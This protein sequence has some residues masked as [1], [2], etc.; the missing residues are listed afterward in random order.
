MMTV[1]PVYQEYASWL[2]HD[3]IQSR[4]TGSLSEELKG[5]RYSCT[6]RAQNAMQN[7]HNALASFEPGRFYALKSAAIGAGF[8]GV[9]LLGALETIVRAGL[10]AIGLVF[11]LL[12]K[13]CF[14]H[15]TSASLYNRSINC[16][17]MTFYNTLQAAISVGTQW[18]HS[19]D[20]I[21]YRGQAN[22]YIHFDK[23]QELD[24]LEQ[25]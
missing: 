21:N 15:K 11:S 3:G 19:R 16:F 1:N 4:Q 7:H 13:F 14:M 25:V 9:S 22:C 2:H 23:P 5:C 20:E 18:T 24:D 17:S 8:V 6:A 12:A 10:G